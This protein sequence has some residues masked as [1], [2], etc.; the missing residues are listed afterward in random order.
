[1]EQMPLVLRY[2]DNSGTVKEDFIKFAHCE[3]GTSGQAIADLIKSKIASLD[4]SLDNCRGQGCDG[5]RKMSGKYNGA[6]VLIRNDFPKA[7]Y[8]HCASHRLNL[9]VTSSC[10]IIAIKNM[11]SDVKAVSDFF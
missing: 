3:S 5:A 11:M 1:M 9:C 10:K 6:A 8:V 2:V 7:L 4:L